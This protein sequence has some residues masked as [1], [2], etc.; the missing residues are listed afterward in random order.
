MGVVERCHRMDPMCIQSRLQHRY[1]QVLYRLCIEVRR[2][3]YPVGWGWPRAH[4]PFTPNPDLD[5][6]ELIS[7]AKQKNVGCHSMAYMAGCGD[8]S[9][10]LQPLPIGVWRV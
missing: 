5:L 8:N 3:V 4:D 9:T 2:G 1:L 10:C 6:K 7:Y